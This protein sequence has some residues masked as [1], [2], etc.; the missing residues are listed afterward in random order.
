MCKFYISELAGII[1]EW[2]DNVHGVTMKII[3]KN[4]FSKFHIRLF[5]HLQYKYWKDKDGRCYA[6]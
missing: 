1:I 3:N 4:A 5:N 2:L 6:M